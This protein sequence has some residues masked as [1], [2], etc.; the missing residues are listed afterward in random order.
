MIKPN[1]KT[2]AAKFSENPQSTFEWFCYLIFCQEFKQPQGIYRYKNQSGIETSPIVKDNEVIGWQAKYYETT[3]SSHKDDLLEMIAK[4]KRDYPS[5][6]KLIFY[7]NQEW[8]QGKSQNDPKA[9]VAVEQKALECEIKIE[10]RT[11]SF[12]ESPFVV[13]DNETIA[14][15]FFILDD[16]I[17]DLLKRKQSHTEN[18][19]YEIQT[20]IEFNAHKIE[21]DRSE[22][23][24]NIQGELKQK[25]I[26]ILSGVGGVGKTAVI[27]NLYKEIKDKTPFYIFKANEFNINNINDLFIDFNLQDFIEAHKDEN[28]K[29]I[30]I[31]SAEKLLDLYNTDPFKECLSALIKN[32]WKI[33]FTTRNNYLEDL[34]YQF[35]EIYRIIPCNLDVQILDLKEL[36]GLSQTYS[37]ILPKDQKL[38]ELIKN[39]FYL[40][41][42]LKFYKKEENIDYLN[43]KEKLWNIIIKKSKPNREQCFLQIV[44]QRISEGQFFVTPNCDSKIMTELVQEGVLGYEKAGYF[45]TQDIY[46][47]WALEKIIEIEYIKKE[48]NKKY[49]EEIGKSLPIRRSFRNWVS[50]KL[51]LEDNSIKQFVEEVIEDQEIDSHWKDEIL[52]SVLLSDY[53]EKAFEL[54]KEI[55]LE[56]NY[57][58]LKRMTFMLRIACKE[59][60]DDFFKQLGIKDVNLFSM[61]YVFTKPKGK[62]WQCLIKYVYDNLDKIGIKNIYFIL[63][64]IH[65]WNSKFKNGGTTRLS[66]LIALRYYQWIIKEDVYFSRDD[67]KDH[68]LETILYGALEIKSE[69]DEILKEIIRNKWKNHRDPYCDLSK[70]ILT[71][72]EG[73]SV[74]RVLPTYVLQLANLFW[75]RSS[76]NAPFYADSGMG[77][78]QYF[79]V[80]D[81]HLD[82]FP[83][84]S[85]QTPIYWLL[86]VS[87]KETIDFILEFTNK[88]VEYFAK[89]AFAK[90]EVEEV[91]VFVDEGHPLKQYIGNRLWCL[92]RGT[93][94]VPNVLES[95]H[96]ALEKFFLERGKDVDSKT[97]EGWLLY[98]L[99]NSKSA[100]I[101]AVVTSIVLAY[102]EKTF[103]V[104]IILFQTKEFFL[105]DTGRLILDQQQKSSLLMRRNSFGSR[106]EN[107][108]YEDER[109][110]ACDDE[111]RKRSL[112]NLALNYQFFRSEGVDEKEAEKRQITIWSIFD[113]Y[114]SELPDKSKE[115]EPDKTWRLYLARMDRRKMKP[116]TEEKDGQVLISFNPEIDPELEKYRETSLKKRIEPMKYMPLKLWASYKMRNDEKYKQ[117]EQYENNPQLALKEAEEIVDNIGKNENEEF[118]LFNY[119]I[120][121]QVCSVLVRDHFEKLSKKGK[122]ICKKIVLEYARS[123][124]T[125]NYMYQVSDGSESTIPVLSILLQECPDEKENIKQ[126]LLLTLFNEYTIDMAGTPFNAFPIMAI[127]KLWIS[128]FDDAQS[129]LFGY[130]LLKPKYERLRDKLRKENYKKNIYELHENEII[131]KFL[132]ENEVELQKVIESQISLDDLKDVEKID[133]GILK[134]AFQLIPLKTSNREH[135]QLVQYII[136]TFAKDLL[137]DKREDKVDYAIMHAFLE[138]LSYFILSSSEQDIPKYLRPFNDNFNGSEAIA[139]LFKEIISA[140]DRLDTYKNFWV[141]WNLFYNNIV[142]L[143]KDGDRH[144]Y[145]DKVIK[146]YLFARNSWKETAISWHTLK[147]HDKMFFG[148]IAKDIGHCSS[149]L[150]SISKILND[151]GSIYLEDGISWISS[152]LNQ[153]SN[154]WTDKLE[155]NTIYYLEM[156]AKKYIYNNREKIK[157]IS[158]IKHENLVILNFL[159]EKGSV[160]GYMLREDIL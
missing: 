56:N 153:N 145:V 157:K 105:Y 11:A 8:G 95:M 41:E 45:I 44:F 29:T 138:K 97:L 129:L 15:H 28:N 81:D 124:L 57:E 126:I 115:T 12:F 47:E 51:L 68:L 3:L 100:S 38:L 118:Y 64:I 69:L 82:Y 27:K 5:L 149:V 7:T 21:I 76:K 155:T 99:N 144:W 156:Y 123:P 114:Y 158:K 154:L 141:V 132:K 63:P 74:S 104:A 36:I 58:L 33:I 160:V 13:M 113:K 2:F 25:Q 150:Y 111:H 55:L 20:S 14:R 121:A 67:T 146:S 86:Q 77:M 90:H 85:Y 66:S 54:L 137:S 35:I 50:E 6:A 49:F 119:S 37:F 43:F 40:N 135:K 92:F 53:S 127:N 31:D 134:T 22:V 88:T 143:C 142:E 79:D 59:V 84:S 152:M 34:N 39:P 26:L 18:I 1:W 109:I 133:L 120:P 4:S 117:Y 52:V 151:I 96:M 140:E 94:V 48:N 148:K 17:F 62:G 80:E 112:E 122:N 75:S 70:V 91:E 65:D 72:L 16:S 24:H 19:L 106:Y 87:L 61:K 73:I 23:L 42:Y 107:K 136:S 101:S 60:D 125:P 128:G 30:V 78:E 110:K 93:Q 9:K 130:L 131:E 116:T 102:P 32:N 71:N 103:N 10:W 83:A 108:V 98:L 46:E 89:L 147:G 139:K 159:V